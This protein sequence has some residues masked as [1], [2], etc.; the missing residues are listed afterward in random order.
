MT[1]DRWRA[2]VVAV[3]SILAAPASA[4]HDDGVGFV[5]LYCLMQE[6]ERY[7]PMVR[8]PEAR[9]FYRRAGLS[10]IGICLREHR[11]A[12]PGLCDAAFAVPRTSPPS[13]LEVYMLD[14]LD[15]AMRFY[16]FG[17][18]GLPGPPEPQPP[19]ISVPER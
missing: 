13:M 18:C 6:P 16:Y 14:H 9:S 2:T 7:L 10:E 5:Q 12:S 8:D 11:P 1:V 15:E 3:L 19:V 4:A 17:K